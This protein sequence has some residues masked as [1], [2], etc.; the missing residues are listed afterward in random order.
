MFITHPFAKNAIPAGLLPDDSAQWRLIEVLLY[1]P[2]FIVSTGQPNPSTELF[3]CTTWCVGSANDLREILDDKGSRAVLELICVRPT[4]FKRQGF[5]EP[6]TITKV[7][8]ARHCDDDVIC[9][10]DS[11]GVEFL[12]GPVFEEVAE[13][14]DR[15]LLWESSSSAT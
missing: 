2:W 9:I 4:H 12:I 11:R 13:V 6:V 8:L 7:W 14:S 3:D 1:A 5:W 15:M 10:S